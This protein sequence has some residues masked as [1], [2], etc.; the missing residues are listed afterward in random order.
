M[1]S[2]AHQLLP[3]SRSLIFSRSGPLRVISKCE[4]EWLSPSWS[5]G[6]SWTAVGLSVQSVEANGRK[7]RL[8][9]SI[10]HFFNFFQDLLFH[11]LSS[12]LFTP[13][14][15]SNNYWMFPSILIFVLSTFPISNL[16]FTPSLYISL[17]PSLPCPAYPPIHLLQQWWDCP[18]LSF[19]TRDLPPSISII[20]LVPLF[21]FPSSYPDQTCV[22]SLRRGWGD[23]AESTQVAI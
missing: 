14:L 16:F 12:F 9:S 23:I 4:S 13:S 5:R 21:Y 11:Q 17:P 19:L 15:T 10:L 20:F 3:L 2:V 8:I 22:P 1:R 7:I 18:L 6:Q